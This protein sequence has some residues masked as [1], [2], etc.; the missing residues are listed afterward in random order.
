MKPVTVNLVEYLL[1]TLDVCE[2]LHDVDL[3]LRV[4]SEWGVHETVVSE[5]RAEQ[6]ERI[7]SLILQD[8]LPE[9]WFQ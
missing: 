9:R 2:T 4:A 5:L 7:G 8:I 6:A 3:L 1:S